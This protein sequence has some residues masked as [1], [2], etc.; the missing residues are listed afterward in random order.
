MATTLL[1]RR[2][3]GNRLEPI[4]DMGREILGHLDGGIVKV[5]LTKARNVGHHRKL[6]ALLSLIYSNQSHYHSVEELLD[7]I[8]VYVGHCSVMQLRDGTEV[9]VPKSI[10]FSN[11]DQVEFNAFW[12]RVVKVVCEQILPGVTAEEL[13]RELLDLVA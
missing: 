2:T 11:M 3:L 5:A 13:E 12:D 10:S 9:R 4:D 6:F 8:K 1:M 7:A